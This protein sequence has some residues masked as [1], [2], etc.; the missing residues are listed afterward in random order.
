MDRSDTRPANPG[1][2]G[3]FDVSTAPAFHWQNSPLL[4]RDVL[5]ASLGVNLFSLALPMVV[6]Q[7]YDR[8]IPNQATST[9]L[10]L[11]LG[12]LVV[13]ILDS[14]LKTARAYLAGWIGARFEHRIGMESVEKILRAD[15]RAVE[16][17]A[18]GRHLDRLAGVDLVRDFYSSQASIAIIDLPFVALFLGLFFYIAGSLVLLPLLLLAVFSLSAAALG[19]GLHKALGERSVWDDRRY[20][21]II[22]TLSGI[23]TIKSM[24]MERLIERRYERLMQSCS[25]A[26]MK[27]VYFSGLAQSLGSSF[28]QITMVS[29]VA[30]GSL[31]VIDGRLSI[32]GLAACTL[33][34]G[35]A[36]QPVLRA[37]GLWTRFQS[38]QVAEEKLAE[39]DKYAPRLSA[40]AADPEPFTQLQFERVSFRF[41]DEGRHLLRDMSLSVSP[42]EIIGIRGKNG[43]GKSTLL[44]LMMGA[45]EPSLGRVLINGQDI[46]KTG[47]EKWRQDIA[48]LAQRPVL[49]DGSVME[50]IT[51]FCDDQTDEALAIAKTL[52]LD[53]VFARYPEGFDT[54]IGARAVSNLAGGVG[55]SVAAARALL[56]RP[57]LILFDEANAAM[58]NTGDNLL[59][60]AL[61]RHRAD[62]AIVLISYRPSLLAIATSRFDLKEGRLVRVALDGDGKAKDAARESQD[63][64]A[65]S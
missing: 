50:N 6:L 51:M 23:H 55:Q 44:R 35:R 61:L 37:L 62:A 43:S 41:A 14:I 34:A 7:V 10:L 18:P 57:K 58:D 39:L 29:V 60:E 32:G 26:G 42:G 4:R 36:V 27:T 21:F 1:T 5:G 48:Y 64:G 24:A 53:K 45:L 56:R 31:Y 46:A 59:R 2:L 3:E 63:Q 16:A 28:S 17:E 54:Q 15:P 65:A 38:I 13:L 12:M 19:R 22:E 33:L 40:E 25:M 30:V 49:F 8:I 52:G 47:S 20:S 11:V 9:L